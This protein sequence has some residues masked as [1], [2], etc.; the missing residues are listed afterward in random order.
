[1]TLLLDDRGPARY[2][3]V[4]RQELRDVFKEFRDG[5][6]KTKRGSTFLVQGPP[7]AGKT[8]LLHELGHTATGWMVVGIKPDALH[9]PVVLA[10]AARQEIAVS[11]TRGHEAGGKVGFAGT[12]AGGRRSWSK[13][14]AGA[15]IGDVVEHLGKESLG[16]LLI[17]DEA[18]D[19]ADL[20]EDVLIR[21]AAKSALKSIHNG[22]YVGPVIL[23]AGGLGHSERAFESLGISRF[24]G[25]AVVNLGR[26]SE[27]AA[28]ELVEDFL[29]EGDV[30]RKPMEGQEALVRDIL[31]R[32]HGWPQHLVAYGES[33]Q[34]VLPDERSTHRITED[35]RWRIIEMGDRARDEYYCKRADNL[36]LQEAALLG[37]LAQN[38]YGARHWHRAVLDKLVAT[39]WLGEPPAA[40]LVDRAIAKGVLAELPQAKVYHI[41]IPS[42]ADW[43]VAQHKLY[44]ALAPG[45]AHELTEAVEAVFRELHVRRELG[46]KPSPS[47][48]ELDP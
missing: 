19:I 1:M 22:E 26:L 46:Q 5:A 32:C 8:A 41:P 42:M 21:K 30:K 37:A 35:E 7:G 3:F 13:E 34:R 40:G 45:P 23:L 47:S 24:R 11:E 31:A 29:R 27:Q 36:E 33:A 38:A 2:G 12:E 6:V 25:G 9:D 20:A 17:L 4:G 10:K 14:Y 39:P 28:R 15:D 18:Q 44:N 48:R 43:L 16:V